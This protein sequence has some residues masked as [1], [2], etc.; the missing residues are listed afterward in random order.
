MRL[1]VMPVCLKVGVLA[2]LAGVP[3]GSDAQGLIGASADPRSS[4]TGA[5]EPIATLRLSSGSVVRFLDLGEGRAAVAEQAIG[6]APLMT[7]LLVQRWDATPLEMFSALAPHA[8]VPDLLRRDHDAATSSPPRSLASPVTYG[9]PIDNFDCDPPENFESDW[10][11]T[12]TLVT[13]V[14]AAESYYDFPWEQF[15]W[16]PGSHAYNGT[17]NNTAT[18]FG[19][20]NGDEDAYFSVRVDRRIQYTVDGVEHVIWAHHVTASFGYMGRFTFH[21][22]L[23][24][25]Y[26]MRLF[27]PSKT[28]ISQF[29]AGV[30]FTKGPPLKIVMK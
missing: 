14:V 6:P 4:A 19:L 7:D 9:V 13:D 8:R 27:D 28:P 12:Y 29:A 3:A 1:S 25:I 30:A 2:L 11:D 23:P 24:G 20:C 10:H 22:N 26:R 21:T 5:P 18:H 17:N 15:D 16:W